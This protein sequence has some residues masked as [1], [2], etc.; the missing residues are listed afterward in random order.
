MI[1]SNAT[2]RRVRD[3]LLVRPSVRHNRRFKVGP[4]VAIRGYGPNAR[5]GAGSLVAD[6]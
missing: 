6:Q 2:R 3:K 4:I 5:Y 1:F